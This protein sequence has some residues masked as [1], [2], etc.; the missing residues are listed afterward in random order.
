[1]LMTSDNGDRLLFYDVTKQMMILESCMDDVT[2][3]QKMSSS[4]FGIHL[5]SS[6]T[7]M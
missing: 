3:D 6:S 2:N 7:H 4:V 1:M 5:H